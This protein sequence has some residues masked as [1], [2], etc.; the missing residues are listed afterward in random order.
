M[1]A[2]GLGIDLV[3]VDRIRAAIEER[4]ERF[5]ARLFTETEIAYCRRHQDAAIH[6]AGRFCAKEALAKALG[7]GFGK[8]VSWRE[9]EVRNDERGAPHFTFYGSLKELIGSKKPLLSITHTKT[10]ASAVVVIDN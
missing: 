5:L 2:R 9:I 6:F 3:E 1:T 7:L 8:E 4:G 10:Y